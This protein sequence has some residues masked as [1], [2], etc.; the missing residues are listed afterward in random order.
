[1]KTRRMILLSLAVGAII[2]FIM[3]G[4]SDESTS[5]A[6]SADGAPESAAMYTCSMHPHINQPGPGQCPLC[7]MDLI[8]VDRGGGGKDVGPRSIE[9]SPAARALA[10]VETAVVVKQAAAHQVRLS[11]TVTYD[12]T[13]IR[14]VTMLSEGQVR[15]LN[16]NY[17]GKKFKTGDSLADIY[18]PDVFAASRELVV[19]GPS[20]SLA[21]ASRQKLRLLGVSESQINRITESGESTDT[22]T[23]MSPINGVM[24]SKPVREGQWLMRGEH[25]AELTDPSILWVD[26]DAYEQDIGMIQTGQSVR[27]AVESLPGQSF[28][29]SVTFVAPEFD[30]MKRS[31]RV[32][33]EVSNPDE[34]LKPG[35]FARA[36]VDVKFPGETILIPASAPLIT[37]RRAVVYVQ[38]PDDSSIFEGREIELG[39]R[40]GDAYVVASGLAEGERIAVRGAMRIDSSLQIQAKPSMM[41]AASTEKFGRQ[42][43]CPIEHGEIDPNVSV[44]YQGMRIYF[45]CPGCD[46]DFLADPEKY[47]AVMRAKGI[48]PERVDNEEHHEHAH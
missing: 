29:G 12:E 25:I 14:R 36:E 17:S 18:S 26:L 10:R 23:I 22:F 11:G 27:V 4:G 7:G 19:A 20:G 24:T 2:G 41:S 32:R 21:S 44:I 42:T 5:T 33:L 9:L 1:M 6:A 38:S 37:G 3:R 8:P 35:M 45:C 40:A 13:R 47:I 30:E 16:A 43:H 28:T 39:M 15:T 48:E 34:Q 31:V 46:A